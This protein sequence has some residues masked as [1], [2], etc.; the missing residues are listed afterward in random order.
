[1][2]PSDRWPARAPSGEFSPEHPAGTGRT[3]AA[4]EDQQ[5]RR[6]PFASACDADGEVTE[7]VKVME[8]Q[9]DEFW[10]FEAFRPALSRLSVGAPG[11]LFEM[12][13]VNLYLADVLRERLRRCPEFISPR[14]RRTLDTADLN[15][16]TP[17]EAAALLESAVAEEVRRLTYP[18]IASLLA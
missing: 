11:F 7:R 17:D 5:G 9:E 14:S 12:A 15:M 4:R 2:R 18:A 8:L 6:L 10:F 16:T 13:L 1:M 3:R